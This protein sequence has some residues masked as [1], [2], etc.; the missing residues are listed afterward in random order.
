MI[1]SAPPETRDDPLCPAAPLIGL[2]DQL[3][4]ILRRVDP[5]HYTQ[6]PVG[7]VSGSLGGHV[8]HCL[9]HVR[10]L[11]AALDEGRLD[12]DH[13]R[14]DT[15]IENDPAAAL[16]ESIQLSGRCR[17]IDSRDWDQPLELSLL[18]SS[19]EP[20]VKA[21][22]TFGRELAYVLSHTIHHNAL[23][24]AILSTLGY[25]LPPR[26]GYAPS[27]LAYQQRAASCAR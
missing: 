13:R 26:F 21:R 3:E 24:G 9:D 8:R 17:S 4:S 14:R 25:G 19:D 18:M 6:K 27:T 1:T 15:A 2:L 10:S 12:Y 23:I 7:P 11:L 22:S 5:I 20:P 16:V